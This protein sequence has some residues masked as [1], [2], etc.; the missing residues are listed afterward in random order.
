[1]FLLVKPGEMLRS[2][3]DV[4][5]EVHLAG[6]LTNKVFTSHFAQHC[7]FNHLCRH[8]QNQTRLISYYCTDAQWIQLFVLFSQS[9]NHWL[10]INHLVTMAK[11]CVCLSSENLSQYVSQTTSTILYNPQGW[12]NTQTPP[13]KSVLHCH[14]SQ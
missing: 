9:L 8:R 7:K 13:K 2:K 1:M 3:K 5:Q 10:D 11:Q 12:E 4:T 14:D 6:K